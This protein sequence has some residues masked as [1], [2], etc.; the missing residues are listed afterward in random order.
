MSDGAQPRDLAMELLVEAGVVLA[1]SLELPT[2]M[3]QV[4][5]LTV[6]RLAD[7]CVID[8]RDDDGVDREVAVVA[9]EETLARAL[10]ELARSTSA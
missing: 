2:T 8:L 5:R 4:A 3:D 9:A 10:E 1:S 7:L 6:P